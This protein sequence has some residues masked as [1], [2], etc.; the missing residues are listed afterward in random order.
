MKEVNNS[1]TCASSRR[2]DKMQY[3]VYLLVGL[4]L[5]SFLRQSKVVWE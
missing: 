2:V 3:N 1:H 4:E 5:A